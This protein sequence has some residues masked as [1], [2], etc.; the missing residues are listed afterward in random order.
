M[1]RRLSTGRAKLW[2]WRVVR[3]AAEK[4][5]GHPLES[6]VSDPLRRFPLCLFLLVLFSLSEAA[7]AQNYRAQTS[8]RAPRQPTGRY[9]APAP[10][11]APY[12]G[13]QRFT[14]DEQQII[15]GIT[16]RN[17]ELGGSG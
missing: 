3:L 5:D 4:P 10:A 17:R 15:D 11:P 13:Y 1:S 2:R 8:H 6:T 9:Y 16:R 12:Q 14:P 7:S